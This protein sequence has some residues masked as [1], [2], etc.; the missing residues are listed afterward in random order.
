MCFAHFIA[1]RGV[2]A[3]HRFALARDRPAQ[4]TQ[5]KPP[6]QSKQKRAETEKKNGGAN[7][8]RTDDLFNAIEALYQLSYDPKRNNVARIERFFRR[9][10][11]SKLRHGTLRGN[12]VFAI[13]ARAKRR[14][15]IRGKEFFRLPFRE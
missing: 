7:Q 3:S 4:H 12:G 2:G 9:G 6:F 10:V 13:G 15:R 5:K 11:N 1:Y 8:D 14:E